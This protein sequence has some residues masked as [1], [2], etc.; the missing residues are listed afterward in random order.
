[1]SHG[2]CESGI[3]TGH[4]GDGV[5]SEGSFTVSVDAGFRLGASVPPGV[6]S[7]RELVWVSS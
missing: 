7:L 1:M 2:F 4:R 3:Q 6:V 5:D